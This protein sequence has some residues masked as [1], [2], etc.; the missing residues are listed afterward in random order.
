MW[1]G[2]ALCTDLC[3]SIFDNFCCFS[4]SYKEK[5]NIPDYFKSTSISNV[6]ISTETAG[7]TKVLPLDSQRKADSVDD[8][9]RI[10]SLR[11]S[12]KENPR[13]LQWRSRE[14]A[15]LFPFSLQVYLFCAINVMLHQILYDAILF[16]LPFTTCEW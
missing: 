5:A 3:D 15:C 9:V 13:N 11:T 6:Q 16:P 1:V 14:G 4:V 7:N 8:K 12:N 2:Q 10:A